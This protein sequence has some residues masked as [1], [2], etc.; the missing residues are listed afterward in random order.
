MAKKAEIN[1][2]DTH[3]SDQENAD[4]R[5]KLRS[6][7]AQNPSPLWRDIFSR[8]P[9]MMDVLFVQNFLLLW[10]FWKASANKKMHKNDVDKEKLYKPPT[11]N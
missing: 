2:R 1:S 3:L 5:R 4:C 10:K 6:M 7:F 8:S 9:R 11:L